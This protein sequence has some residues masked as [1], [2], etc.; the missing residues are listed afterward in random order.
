MERRPRCFIV[1]EPLRRDRETGEFVPAM[2]FRKVLPYGDPVVL[3]NSGPVSL[4][5]G[6]TIDR[7]WEKLK[8][9]TDEDY[10]V[11]VGDPSAMFIA[12]QIAGYQTNGKCKVLKWDKLSREYI[13]VSYDIHYR[14]RKE[15]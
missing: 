10:L 9:F 4:T 3:L 5:P 6:I 15:N 14:T 11:P 7:L 1:Q 8:D 2:D 12:A 13:E